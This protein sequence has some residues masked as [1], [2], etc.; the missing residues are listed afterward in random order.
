VISLWGVDVALELIDPACSEGSCC[1]GL[2]CEDWV[3]MLTNSRLL[4]EHIGV[5]GCNGRECK[6][7]FTWSR[8]IE[9]RV[10]LNPK[11]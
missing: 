11:P 4:T 3:T 8:M 10:T 6:L 7:L 2:L 9:V 5:M 1:A